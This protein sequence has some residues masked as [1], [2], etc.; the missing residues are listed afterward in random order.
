MAVA[1]VQLSRVAWRGRLGVPAARGAQ[2]L[3]ASGFALAQPLFDLLGKNAEFFAVRGSTAGDIVVF[4]LVVTFAP[5]LVLL[6][7]ELLVATVSAAAADVVHHVFLV[8]LG[9]VFG[10]Q[11]LKRS[12]VSGTIVLIAGALLIGVALAVAAWRLRA[13]RSFL[14]LLSAAPL[15]FL[16]LFLLSSPVSKLIVSSGGAQAAAIRVRATTPV[17]FLLFDELPVIDLQDESGAID[18]ARFPNFARLAAGSTWFRNT[19]TLSATTTVAVPAI[20]TGQKPVKGALPIFHDH[21]NNLFTLLG[22]RYRMQVTESQTRLCPQ[23]LCKRKNGDT[24]S[25]LSSLY[26]DVKV[27]YLH[28]VSPPA[29]EDRLPVVDESWGNFG[30]SSPEALEF[31][32]TGAPKVD[33]RTFYLSRVRDFNRF[34]K[35]FRRPGNGPPTLY[36]IHV[37]L[38]HTPWLYFPDGRARAVAT[39]NAPGRNGE[40]WVNGQLAVQAWQR[41]LLQVGFTDRL[42]GRFLSRLHETGLWDKA[43]VVVTADHGISFRGGDLRRRP[44]RRNL[45]ELAFTPLFMR[46]PGEQEGRVVDDHVQTVDILPTIADVLGVKVPWKVDGRSALTGT[47]PPTHVDVAGVVARY[48]AALAQRRASLVRQ[49]G[50]FGSGAWGPQ[51]AGTGAYRR[52]VGVSVSTFT[53]ATDAGASAKVDAVGSKLLRRLPPGSA[54]VPS[55]LAGTLAGVSVGQAVAVSLNGRIAAVSF[56]Y[57]NPGGGPVRFSAL[58]AESAFRTGR[59]TVRVFVLTG[60]PAH[61]RLKVVTTRL[62]G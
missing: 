38:P 18:A 9:A 50:L 36:F 4:A 40:L 51:L 26:S 21:P 59:N 8:F 27:V 57:R 54:L 34:V 7:V 49:L 42:L 48:P 28:L 47:R 43:L 37:L 19:T 3:A 5:A 41:H 30:S 11:V 22:K 35:S 62:S 60:S 25:R 16:A 31:A 13:V 53:T 20:L 17:V 55:P 44:T 61:A 14:T 10:V 2:L 6:A 29:L 33:L 32:G 12:G 1:G 39:P 52:L 58:A 23:K 56:A 45:A 46:L 24:G 15:V